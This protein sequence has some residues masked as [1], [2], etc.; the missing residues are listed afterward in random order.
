MVFLSVQGALELLRVA[1]EDLLE[2]LPFGLRRGYLLDQLL[3][4]G[5]QRL[6]FIRV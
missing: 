3:R 5:A 1:L 2:F 4:L 6:Q